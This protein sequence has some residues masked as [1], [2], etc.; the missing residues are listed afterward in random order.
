M[1]KDISPLTLNNIKV[2]ARRLKNHLPEKTHSERLDI[3]SYQI[4]GFDSYRDAKIAADNI[5][6]KR[7]ITD[8]NRDL[9]SKVMT[10]EGRTITYGQMVDE[11]PTFRRGDWYFYPH[12]RV[13]VFDGEF[14]P[15]VFEIDRLSNS[16]ELLDLILQ[17]QK[18]KWSKDQIKGTTVSPTYQV[19][20]LIT[21]ID[22]LC[23]YYFNNSIQGVFSPAGQFKSVIWPKNLETNEVQERGENV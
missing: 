20:E 1:T 21:L 10:E 22:Q 23:H 7:P 9:L 5:L 12:S 3:A 13:L 2:A 18:K 6:K 19:D 17:I 8:M 11:K 4:L 15:Y 16:T 14:S